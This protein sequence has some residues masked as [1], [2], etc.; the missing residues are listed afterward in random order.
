MDF[1]SCQYVFL[2]T[3]NSPFA[4]HFVSVPE[5]DADTEHFGCM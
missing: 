1:S 5:S 2:G 4:P 3:Q